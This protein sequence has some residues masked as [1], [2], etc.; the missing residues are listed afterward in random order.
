MGPWDNRH[1]FA[2]GCLAGRACRHKN[3]KEFKLSYPCCVLNVMVAEHNTNEQYQELVPEP[4]PEAGQV[5]AKHG[6]TVVPGA[7]I[8]LK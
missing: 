2:P 8:P 5:G 6:M 3:G 1:A 4:E 7:G